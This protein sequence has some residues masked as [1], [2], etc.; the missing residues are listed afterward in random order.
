MEDLNQNRLF[1]VILIAYNRKEFIGRA[2]DSIKNQTLDKELYELICITNYDLEIGAKESIHVHHIKMTGTIGEFIRSGIEKA[3]GKFICILEDDDEFEEYKLEHIMKVLEFTDFD[4]YKDSM[5]I[6]DEFDNLINQNKESYHSDRSNLELIDKNY[7]YSL[8]KL[9]YT[10]QM[11]GVPSTLT[12]KRDKILKI[13]DNMSLIESEIGHYIYYRFIDRDL[14]LILDHRQLTRYRISKI[15]DSS[16]LSYS[17]YIKVRR[18]YVKRTMKT[19]KM[20]IPALKDRRIK[21]L[22]ANEEASLISEESFIN[23]GRPKFTY[24]IKSLKFYVLSKNATK[25]II[26]NTLDIYSYLFY[27]KLYSKGRYMIESRWK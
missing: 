14:K 3:S 25:A 23:Y 7:Y 18:N 20:L 5:S 26:Y 6:I 17:D 24:F 11:R 27:P 4:Y 10:F 12:F 19:Y 13:L 2:I 21:E 8:R 16:A 9:R 1:S 15:S 22:V